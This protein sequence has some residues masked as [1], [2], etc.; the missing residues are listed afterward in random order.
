[1]RDKLILNDGT[2]IELKAAASLGGMVTIFADWKAVSKTMTKL[3]GENLSAVMVQ[4]GEG[5]TA[6]NYANL[7]MQPGA[8]EIKEDGIHVTISLR[9]KT[10]IEKRLDKVE[11]GQE[12][13]GGAIAELAGISGGDR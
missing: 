3:T 1:M 9:E 7:V 2:T 13:Q 8:W 10:D 12:V 11:S 6:G 4:T 5:F